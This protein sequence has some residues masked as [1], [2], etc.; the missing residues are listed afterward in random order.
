[1]AASVRAM[2]EDPRAA[3]VVLAFLRGTGVGRTISLRPRG[4]E[5]GEEEGE[6]ES[7]GEGGGPGLP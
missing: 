5:G 3:P 2:F 1:M 7:E 6:V 4:E